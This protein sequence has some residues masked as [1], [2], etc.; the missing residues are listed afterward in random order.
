[1]RTAMR[2]RHLLWIL[3]V[4][5]ALVAVPARA[6]VLYVPA[7]FPDLRTAVEAAIDGDEIRVAPG[8]YTGPRNRSIDFAGKNLDLVS[9]AGPEATI[10]D[11]EGVDQAF[12]LHS[13]EPSTSS[14]NGFTIRNGNSM[15]VLRPGGA[16]FCSQAA[17]RIRNCIIED[18]LGCCGGGGIA[19]QT[20]LPT[21]IT[22]CII[23]D[24]RAAPDGGG[25]GAG[26][27]LS[28]NG[29]ITVHRCTI[30][31]NRAIGHPLDRRAIGGGVYCRNGAYLEECLI[32]G[33]ET[34][35]WEYDDCPGGGVWGSGE[36][37]L[38]RCTIAGNRAAAHG[39]GVLAAGPGRIEE[40]L[41]T[42]NLAG[43][44]GGGVAATA[45]ATLTVLS[46]TIAGNRSLGG[47]YVPQPGGGLLALAGA[48]V[49]LRRSILRTNCM[50][51]GQGDEGF[52][53]EG[54]SLSCLCSALFPPGLVVEGTLTVTEDCVVTD[55]LFCAPISCEQAPSPAGDYALS[56]D[57]PC[58]PGNNTC[59]QRMGARD[60]G[61]GPTATHTTSW[62]AI[63]ARFRP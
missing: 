36:F 21:S 6:A 12:Y 26:G 49:T 32:V 25:T 35:G 8:T 15:F 30:E 16:I 1:M 54:G 18:C 7:E 59:G 52:V 22:D 33:N 4:P 27:G 47:G 45:G 48:E 5:A 61:C 39:G 34:V 44:S 31:S 40:C 19:Y 2:R 62:S 50:A 46:T 56:A 10:I 9:E 43:G 53:A 11:L 63:K 29:P 28:L 23:R 60:A 55:P 13:D 51:T 14:I 17:T 20:S 24:C 57:S 58:L 42:G 41:V 38:V 3:L 37:A